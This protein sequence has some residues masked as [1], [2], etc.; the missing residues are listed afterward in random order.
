M[1]GA[2]SLGQAAPSLESVAKARGAAFAIYN[3]IDM[4]ITCFFLLETF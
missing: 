2:F 4:V 1:I 3:T